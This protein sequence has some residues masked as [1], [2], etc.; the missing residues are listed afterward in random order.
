MQTQESGSQRSREAALFPAPPSDWK[1]PPAG[2]V[3]R[4]AAPAQPRFTRE[5]R[6]AVASLLS[7]TDPPWLCPSSQVTAD[8]K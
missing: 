1:A 6:G 5:A 7:H 2:G 4:G 3:Q 8:T